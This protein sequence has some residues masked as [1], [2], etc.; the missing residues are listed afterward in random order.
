MILINMSPN[1]ESLWDKLKE[2]L[3]NVSLKTYLY[4]IGA[5]AVIIA[6][7]LNVTGTGKYG[8][9]NK[10]GKFE[11]NLNQ[12]ARDYNLELEQTP[13][14][15]AV[16]YVENSDKNLTSDLSQSL[17]LTNMYL[18]QNG[19]TDSTAR[20]KI[21]AN[22]VLDYQKRA[23]GKIYTEKDLNIIRSEDKDSLQD[24]YNAIKKAAQD[25]ASGIESIKSISINDSN[26]PTEEDIV[27][28]KGSISA[29]ILNILEIN[30][31]F[32][33]SLTSIP[34]TEAGAVYQ[35]QL[36][37]LIS[38]ESAYMKALAQ[39]DND[40]MKYLMLNGDSYATEFETNLKSIND[41]F[42]NYFVENGVRPQN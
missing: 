39:I 27:A 9:I 30:N 34:A 32:I 1:K 2:V 31:S 35:L 8:K 18:D 10:E 38:K 29:Y 20:G 22:I 26:S 41:S 28:A 15:A 42:N 6:I 37:N 3:S 40:P 23:S 21:L 11:L 14:E 33:N 16:E 17:L 25:Y 13:D 12:I 36:I 19:I 4:A 24:Y 7:L 5:V